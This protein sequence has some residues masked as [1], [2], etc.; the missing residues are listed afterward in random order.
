MSSIEAHGEERH[1]W[2][3][4]DAPSGAPRHFPR[5]ADKM[6]GLRHLAL[7]TRSPSASEADGT[8]LLFVLL[9]ER[10]CV[11]SKPSVN[12]LRTDNARLSN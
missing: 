6:T 1:N 12:G 11:F 10:K 4:W 2:I 7:V 8:E 5:Q 3:E 9:T